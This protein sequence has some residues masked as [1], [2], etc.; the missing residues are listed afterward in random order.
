MLTPTMTAFA[1]VT[2]VVVRETE[3]EGGGATFALSRTA[4][5]Y[6]HTGVPY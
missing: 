5:A 6:L 1:L 3:G 4:V 2:A